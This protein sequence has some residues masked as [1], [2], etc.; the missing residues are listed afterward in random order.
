MTPI[1]AYLVDLGKHLSTNIAAKTSILAKK[2]VK[3]APPRQLD[4]WAIP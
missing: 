2:T 1:L 3:I 4:D